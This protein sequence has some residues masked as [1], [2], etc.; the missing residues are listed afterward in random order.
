M[1]IPVFLL[2][3]RLAYMLKAQAGAQDFLE[4]QGNYFSYTAGTKI[5]G[6]EA[7]GA[8]HCHSCLDSQLSFVR[9]TT[10]ACGKWAFLQL[11]H[12]VLS[13]PWQPLPASSSSAKPKPKPSRATGNASL[14]RPGLLAAHKEGA[15]VAALNKKALF[16]SVAYA[17]TWEEVGFGPSMGEGG[18]ENK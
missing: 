9:E 18:C 7:C 13:E 14:Q 10:P 3:S 11:A 1:Q 4:V 16:S 5:T 8:Q 15:G 2:P 12:H 17:A 6:K